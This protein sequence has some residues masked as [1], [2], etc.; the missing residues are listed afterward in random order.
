MKSC[1]SVRKQCTAAALA[2]LL[3][4]CPLHGTR[5]LRFVATASVAGG[6]SD[7]GTGRDSSLLAGV[8]TNLS[9]LAATGTTSALAVT[10]EQHP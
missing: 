7:L 1:F 10:V 9:A 2:R 6:H 5:P 8:A 3:A 4:P